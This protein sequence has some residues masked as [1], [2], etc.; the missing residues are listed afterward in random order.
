MKKYL[1]KIERRE[2][3]QD[4]NMQRKEDTYRKS[5]WRFFFLG[6]A[7]LSGGY[8]LFCRLLLSLVLGM[9]G[10]T[11]SFSPNEAATIGIIGGADGPTAIFVTG[12]TVL[13]QG[14]DWELL[15]IAVV[16]VAS[17]AAFLRLR[18]CRRK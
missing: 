9:D 5:P 14:F 7:V 11:Q 4:L 3:A 2:A 18:K 15:L 6:L 16:F 1:K 10:L 13:G 8:L 12:T 17:V